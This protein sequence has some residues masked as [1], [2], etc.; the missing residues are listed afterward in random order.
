MF[1]K[2][3]AALKTKHSAI[4]KEKGLS[5]KALQGIAKTLAITTTEETDI[6]TIVSADGVGEAL[7]L[8]QSEVDGRVTEAVKKAKGAPVVGK[9]P[10]KEEKTKGDE[11]DDLIKE[12][13]KKHTALEEQIQGLKLDNSYKSQKQILESELKDAPE[14]FKTRLLKDFS[15]MKF[16]SDEDF[17]S[18]LEDVKKDSETAVQAF[19]DQKLDSSLISP[20]IPDSGGTGDFISTLKASVNTATKQ[21]N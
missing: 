19:A 9:E 3:L 17:N 11:S 21:E 20:I 4:I 15:R 6:E 2:I 7:G 14:V 12:L 5:D 10:E 8:I 1:E 13:L 18:Y 16:E